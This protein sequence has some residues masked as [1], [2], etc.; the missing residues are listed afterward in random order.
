V[1][2]LVLVVACGDEPAQP[3]VP[4]PRS[5]GGAANLALGTG[6]PRAPEAFTLPQRLLDGARRGDEATVERAL[7]MGA[8]LD[9]TDELGRGVVM[10][11][12]MDAGD[13][14]LVQ[15]LKE[16]G[17]AVDAPDVGGRTA[18]SW[19]A[20]DG[21]L[22]IVKVL[23]DAGARADT[24]DMQGRTPLFHATLNDE[25]DV[26]A[27]LAA[28]GAN[29]NVRDQFG[30]TPLIVACAKGN[31]TSVT[32]LLALGADPSVKD[33]EGRTARERADASATVCKTLGT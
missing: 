29:L 9:A 10:L 15:W 5:G 6:E 7:A 8:P 28:H 32:K 24:P 2:A 27:F 12:V 22:D 23:L 25:V 33:Q 31:V 30:D 19:A 14:G 26:V 13:L 1:A 17:A 3:P 16:R 20:A 11:A 4:A 18:L 21:R